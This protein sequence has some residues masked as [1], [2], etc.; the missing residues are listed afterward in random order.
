MDLTTNNKSSYSFP[1]LKNAVILQ[2]LSD[3]GLEITES[4]LMEPNRHRESVRSV[5]LM[6][7]EYGLNMTPKDFSTISM[8]S[9]TRKQ[10]LTSCPELHNESFGEVKFLLAT[11]YFMKVCG[12][13]DFGWKDL[14]TPS[15]KRFRRQLSG[16]INYIKYRE[17]Q[18]SFYSE[19]EEERRMLISKYRDMEQEQKVIIEQ[20][21]QVEMDS[22]REMKEQKLVEQECLDIEKEIAQQNK[23]QT[24]IRQE[25]T[26][27]K[28]KLNELKDQSAT[29]SVA[30]EEVEAEE[31]R[32]SDQ[33]VSSPTR[34]QREMSEVSRKLEDERKECYD[35]EKKL[36]T[37]KKHIQLVSNAEK[38]V[39]NLTKL[40]EEISSDTN[41]YNKIQTDIE[42]AQ[43]SIKDANLHYDELKENLENKQEQLSQ[44]HEMTEQNE[45]EHSMAMSKYESDIHKANEQLH[46]EE[47]DRLNRMAMI[48]AKEA[49]YQALKDIM[50]K[51]N[52][53]A[54][55]KINNV[56][57]QFKTFERIVLEKDKLFLQTITNQ[58]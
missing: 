16:A 58:L 44:I 4:E 52:K 46:I 31:R 42:E 38:D 28:K 36:E 29:L 7:V 26:E 40:M 30:L 34:L 24:S 37:M 25:S 56:I 10:E 55:T 41:T 57:E 3:L 19:L 17:D 12:V 13:H 23:L 32:L 51:E 53:E 14:Q 22:N 43:E 48:E 39:A 9:M 6:F 27:L 35:Y 50:E 5:F 1:L 33:V 54:G 2:C 20:Y 49:Q 11:M 21:E 45:Q 15:S 18:L 47:R 8:E